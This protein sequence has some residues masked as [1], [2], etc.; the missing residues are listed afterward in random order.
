MLC[1][2]VGVAG[3]SRGAVVTCALLLVA[4]AGVGATHASPLSAA[5]RERVIRPGQE[6][7]LADMLGRGAA[8][9]GPC[10]FTG[11]EADGAIVKASY[12]CPGGTVAIELREARQDGTDTVRTAKF[13][14]VA[15]GDSAPPDLL[16]ALQSRIRAREAAVGWVAPP[17]DGAS[18]SLEPTESRWVNAWAVALAVLTAVGAAWLWHAQRRG[19]LGRALRRGA[20][21]TLCAGALALLCE[22]G[23]RAALHLG[24]PRP[25]PETAFE[26]Y[27]VGESTLVGEPFFPKITVPRMLEHMF[28]GAIAGR[29]LV[30][31]NLAQRGAPL[32]P[33]SVAFERELAGR[34]LATPGAVLI[35]SGHNEGSPLVPDADAHPYLPSLIADRSAIVRDLLLALRRRRM[36]GR[37][38]SLGEYEYYLRR[39]IETAQ[40]N[41]LLPILTTMASNIA[42]IEPNA[43]AS[44]G[45]PGAAVIERGLVLERAAQYIAA[46]DLYVAGMA[47]HPEW[48]A[49]LS[50]RAG[51]CEEA[52]GNFDAARE[53]Y[54]AAVDR[55]S[56]R[57]FGRA[58]RAQN[59]LVRG[60]A[61]EYGV[62]LIDAVE[63]FEAHSP[64]RIIGNEL[65]MDGQH[66]TIEGYRLLATAYAH[67]LSQHFDTPVRQPLRGERDVT[68]A[69]GYAASDRPAAVVGAGSWLIATSVGHPF[70]NDRM[71]LAEKRFASAIGQGDDFSAW[72]GI[73]V[74]QA[75]ARGGMLRSPEDVQVLGHWAGYER[76]Y[77]NL[78]PAE[79]TD[80][81]PRFQRHGVDDEVVERLRA[82]QFD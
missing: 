23:Y 56:R 74:A 37:E 26:L 32:Y 50:Y 5:P 77:A 35:M 54:W 61:R 43:D 75:A 62:P 71:A 53:R 22:V 55:D 19:R 67:V 10:T 41:G 30:V 40:A 68:A 57:A 31:K 39:V 36:V 52:L 13:A 69:L 65:I 27:G 20:V 7:L 12:A 73:A 33:Q 2:S 51:R 42:R 70:P 63:I 78:S 16:A 82:R 48:Y 11:G 64:H 17:R 45:D 28:G 66:P 76:S 18:R 81:L 6:A 4:T 24:A 79:L 72:F 15:A 38:R 29:N 47:E 49:S 8:L 60:L 34:N 59:A 1:E 58:T 21:G 80:L 3:N 9:P 14:I 46:R 44:D 25:A